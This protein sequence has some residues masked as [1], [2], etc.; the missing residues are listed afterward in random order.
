[1]LR[2]A[3]PFLFACSLSVPALA[4]E[5]SE[6]AKAHFQAGVS[7][8]Q[9]PDGAR[10]EEAYREFRS[11]YAA[12]PSWKILGNLGICAMKLERDG[13]AIEA[14]E[15]YLA[16]GAAEIPADER[17]QFERDLQTLRTGS[18]AVTMNGLAPGDVVMDRRAPLAGSPVMNR[19][20]VQQAPFALRMRAGRHQVTVQRAGSSDAVWEFDGASAGSVEH[21]FE[22][23]APTTASA[24]APTVSTAVSPTNDMGASSGSNT[25]KILAYSALGVGAVG[26]ALGVI[27]TLQRSSKASDSDTLYDDCVDSGECG[28]DEQQ[29]IETLDSDAASAGTLGVV[30]FVVGAAGLG[31]GVVLLL[32]G[33]DSNSAAKGPHVSPFVGVGRVGLSGTF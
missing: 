30:G 28:P 22:F 4:Q 13:E 12:S 16:D 1:M 26:T 9:D 6:T 10:Y 15:K 32:S 27:F 21:T 17:A 3:I 7:L 20:D 23:A 14:L 29:K 24:P 11:A 31:T 5:I 18:V 2:Y 19:Y 33:S 8:L 25:R